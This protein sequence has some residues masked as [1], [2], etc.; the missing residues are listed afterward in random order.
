MACPLKVAVRLRPPQPHDGKVSEHVLRCC[1]EVTL[2]TDGQTF[3][4]DRVFGPVGRL[5]IATTGLRSSVFRAFR[6]MS[7]GSESARGLQRLCGRL[8]GCRDRGYQRLQL[9]ESVSDSIASRKLQ[10][11]TEN[12]PLKPRRPAEQLGNRLETLTE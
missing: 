12:M 8:G 11:I 3:A 7:T 4:F 10:K 6:E 2:E 5:E 9:Y 1:D